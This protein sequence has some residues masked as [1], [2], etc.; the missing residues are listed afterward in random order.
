M[1]VVGIREVQWYSLCL[2]HFLC[3][4][5]QLTCGGCN[6]WCCSCH[7][8]CC[9]LSSRDGH[10]WCCCSGNLWCCGCCSFAY[11]ACCNSSS[12]GGFFCFMTDMDIQVHPI[13]F[14]LVPILLALW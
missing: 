14:R 1:K 9:C 11:L 10:S 5:R 7:N 2:S 4:H 3:W 13:K 12:C 8:W 6:S